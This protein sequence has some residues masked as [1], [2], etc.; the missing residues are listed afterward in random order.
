MEEKPRRLKGCRC[1]CLPLCNFRGLN[2]E[3]IYPSR[4]YFPGTRH[5]R[6]FCNQCIC[7]GPRAPGE[8]RWW[9]WV[10]RDPGAH[11]LRNVSLLFSSTCDSAVL[12]EAEQGRVWINE[13]QRFWTADWTTMFR[14]LRCPRE[15]SIRVHQDAL[16]HF[17]GNLFP[18]LV[19][20]KDVAVWVV[21]GRQTT[22]FF[23]DFVDLL[24][25]L[26]LHKFSHLIGWT[27]KLEQ[28]AGKTGIH[29]SS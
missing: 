12:A 21:A 9:Q 6:E 1:D 7:C 13:G 19:Q 11:E 3:G 23:I 24:L 4:F 22:T 27:N 26:L 18:S 28:D 10:Q 15:F 29:K 14:E 25:F 2:P 8:F 16:R 17:S 20:N 5:W